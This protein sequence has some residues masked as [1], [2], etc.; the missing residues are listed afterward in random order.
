MA[1]P[2]YGEKERVMPGA[3]RRILLGTVLLTPFA[4]AMSAAADAPS[5]HDEKLKAPNKAP[6]RAYAFDLRDVKLLTGPFRQAMEA[7]RKYLLSTDPDRLLYNFRVTA[8]LPTAAKP[9]GGWDGPDVEVRG[10]H[11]GHYLTACA[12]LYRATGDKQLKAKADRLVRGMAECQA[13]LGNG[14]LSGYPE[15]FFD[16]L[17][18]HQN[19]WVPWYNVHKIYAGLLD[20][21]VL[22]DNRQALEVCKKACDWAAWRIGR[23]TDPELQTILGEKEHGGMADVLACLY[24][25]TG[26]K[27]YL[28][29]AQRFNH[30]SVLDP[31]MRREDRLT[32]LHGN[33]QMP[34]II[35]A[36]RQYELTGDERFRTAA[37]FYW[38][39]V[40][41]ERSYVNGGNTDQEVFSPKET[42]SRHIS[43]QTTETCVVYNM[44]KLTRHLFCWEPRAEYADY[45]ERGLFNQ[46]LASQHPETAMTVYFLPL[47]SGC[48]KRFGTPFDSMWCCTST[49]MERNAM[50]GNSIY[51]HDGKNTLWVNLF[52]A[53]ELTWRSQ[54]VT[55]RQETRFPDEDTT[56]LTLA[57]T[58]PIELTVKLRHPSWAVAGVRVKINGQPRSVQSS[59][60]SYLALRRVWQDGDTIELSTPM[61][62]RTEGFRDNP[63]KWALLY[64]P[65]LLCT[66]T[67]MGN[68]F[69]VALDERKRIIKSLQPV[70]GK[71]LTFTGPAKVFRT[72]AV[73]AKQDPIFIPFYREYQ[74]PYVVYWDAFTPAQWRAAGKKY[75]VASRSTVSASHTWGS[76]S[77]EAPH[78]QIEP[79]DSDDHSIPR[80]TWWDHRGSSE[81]VQY[82]FPEPL[83]L[84][85][86]EVYWFDD[87]GHGACRV[88][89]SWKLFYRDGPT[90][91]PVQTAGPYGVAK[92]RYN[93]VKFRPVETRGLRLEVQLQKDFSSGILEW[94]AD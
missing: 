68:R 57:C 24:G 35:G 54:G 21:Y 7:N 38:Q 86:A 18:S 79:R 84:S 49:S 75:E 36:A 31:L 55:L 72:A 82:D 23:L 93:R 45:Y 46:I 91:L 80:F 37:T 69:A 90:W 70:E 64:G 11:A 16:R 39:S 2:I 17:E 20:M 13:K 83:R 8:G 51:F 56:K 77:G 66:Q 59:P 26:E 71:P 62:L 6:I 94:K 85:E 81:W 30:R 15:T 28:K 9:Y 3:L 1:L 53:S 63:R 87:M 67:E 43:D 73:Q 29:T 61:S 22:A 42:L 4:L 14:Y 74:H 52:I 48:A 41:R 65:I 50:Y 76:D 32:G 34:K 12:L 5:W 92:D 10:A 25:V 78:D 19:V 44:H 40:A 58:E 88:P 27:K 33:T 89:G 60:G 47:K